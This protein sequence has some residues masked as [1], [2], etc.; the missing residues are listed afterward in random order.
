MEKIRIFELAKKMQMD[1]KELIEEITKIG[2]EVKS[3]MSSIDTETARLIAETLKPRKVEVKKVE[4][5]K[6]SEKKE[7][8]PSIEK[9]D[10]KTITKQEEVVEE[11]EELEEVEEV[12]KLIVL[13]E[14]VSVKELAEKLK[15]TTN[16]IIKVLIKKGIMANINQIIDTEIA[17]SVAKEFGFDVK[18]ISVEDKEVSEEEDTANLVPRYPVVTIMGHVD[19]GKTSLLDAIRETNVTDR[20]VGGITQHIGAYN[21]ELEN[22]RVVFL[23]TPGHEAFTAMRARGAHVTDVVVL[24]IAADDGVMPQTIEAIDHARAAGVPILVAVN[25]IDK[26]DANPEKVKKDLVNYG[27][28]PEE[29]G[30]QHIFVE[31]S[32]K[33]K[34]GLKNLLEMLLLEAEMLELKADPHRAARGTVIEAKLDKGRGPVATIL[35]QSGTLRVGD[36]FVTNIYYGKIRAMIDDKGRKISEVGPST[37]VEILGFSGVPQSGDPFTVVSDE[38]KARQISAIRQEKQREE[39]M[40]RSSKVTLDDLF[41]QIE[42][43]TVKELNIIVKADVHGSVEAVSNSLEKLSTDKV[44]LNVIHGSAGGV[45]ETDVMLASASKAIIIGFH[46]RSEPKAVSLAEKEKVELR[47]YTIIY[48]AIS[49]I[50]KA[51]EGL[52]EPTL[53]EKILGRAEVRELFS[54]PKVGIISGCYVTDGKVIRNSKARLIRDNVVVYEGVISSLRRFKEDAKEV[55]SGYECG[56]GIENFNDVKQGDVI[57]AYTYDEIA[58][59]L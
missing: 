17:T 19:H 1:T 5:T 57:E 21:V 26:L 38:R 46:V 54:V 14:V 56:I 59:K 34:T 41:R 2:V 39:V 9:K 13:S 45:T 48:E 52:L 3:H 4:K 29:W 7:I 43:G 37:P 27:L 32:A 31:V 47:F 20:E 53:K 33:E 15:L 55:K 6:P 28:V 51:M 11:V 18:L 23:D 22:G 49:D 24:V 12:E 8:L 50:K 35:V 40:A 10:K 16:E 25:K 42:E 58:T 30:G 36:P 44:K